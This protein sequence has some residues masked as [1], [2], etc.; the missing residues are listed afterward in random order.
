MDLSQKKKLKRERNLLV[1][2]QQWRTVVIYNLI[3]IRL[4]FMILNALRAHS[5]V[6]LNR[7][8]L[9]VSAVRGWLFNKKRHYGS[10]VLVGEV[11]AFKLTRGLWGGLRFI[12]QNFA[13][14][15]ESKCKRIL[16][17]KTLQI[18]LNISMRIT[19]EC[20]K[21]ILIKLIFKADKF[22]VRFKL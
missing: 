16:A 1:P 20:I 11:S 2:S 10:L 7:N 6:S 15:I 18:Y 8:S 5:N 14:Y 3:I 13:F 17:K 4:P 9:S 19:S 21:F 12:M 22:I